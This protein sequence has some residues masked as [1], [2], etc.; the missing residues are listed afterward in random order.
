MTKSEEFTKFIADE[1][2]DIG[3]LF[4][5]KHLQ[6]RTSADPLAN[7]SRGAALEYG[8]AESYDLM[9][10]VAKEYMNKHVAFVYSHSVVDKTEESLRDMIVYE[11]I[12]LYM[13]KKAKGWHGE[14]DKADE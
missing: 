6:Y 7:F 14:E 9:Y 4:T 13:V 12:M 2:S 1:L 8:D 10:E 11:L 5:K 3:K